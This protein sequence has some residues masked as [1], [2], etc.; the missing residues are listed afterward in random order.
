MKKF[1]MF[2]LVAMVAGSA[3]AAGGWWNEYIELSI[4]GGAS[5]QYQLGTGGTGIALDGADLSS[6]LFSLS[7]T[8]ISINYWN[9]QQTRTGGSLFWQIF[10]GVSPVP[11][12]G[13]S[14]VAWTQT[15]LGGNDYIGEW[16][17]SQSLLGAASY[18]DSQT[19]YIQFWANNEG[20]T[21]GTYWLNNGGDPENF[22]ATFDFQAAPVPEPA[23]MSLL[24]LG[25]LAMVLRRKMSK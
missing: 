19:Y 5:T 9:D 25:A 2:A 22:Q 17:G 6:S 16:T 14:S 13:P 11:V 3:F 23:T 8:D 18:N 21:D 24:G 4:N 20:T 12:A 1:L 15:A 10:D 7:L